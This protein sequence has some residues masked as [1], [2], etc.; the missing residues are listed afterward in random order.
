M[1]AYVNKKNKKDSQIK[2]KFF[3]P[4]MWKSF[5]AHTGNNNKSPNQPSKNTRSG[6]HSG[7]HQLG[8]IFFTINDLDDNLSLAITRKSKEWQCAQV[9]V[10]PNNKTWKHNGWVCVNRS[11]YATWHMQKPLSL[12]KLEVSF[13][14][15]IQSSQNSFFFQ[16]IKSI[17]F[18]FF[19]RDHFQIQL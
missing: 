7:L 14:L 8:S 16:Y 11:V 4:N 10:Q 1:V 3:N 19:G 9:P 5:D 13:G 12:L 18:I 17:P 2:Q 15:H 6:H